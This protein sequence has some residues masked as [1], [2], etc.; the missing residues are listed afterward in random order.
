MVIMVRRR[1][2]E[3]RPLYE[4]R[5]HSRVR[6][7]FRLNLVRRESISRVQLARR[8]SRRCIRSSYGDLHSLVKWLSRRVP[9]Q[10][11][12]VPDHA[13]SRSRFWPT[14]GK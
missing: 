11:S 4:S 2:P 10:R 3:D 8:E 1:T 5:E 7:A 13:P 14:S 12:E 6:L 9:D